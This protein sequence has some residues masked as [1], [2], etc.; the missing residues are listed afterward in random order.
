MKRSYTWK[1]GKKRK[2]SDSN[3]D[4]S[5]KG[6][7]RK[8][9]L[10]LDEKV[11][12][13]GGKSGYILEHD[14][15]DDETE[16]DNNDY[17]IKKRIFTTPSNN[18]RSY[19]MGQQLISDKREE[20]GGKQQNVAAKMK[21]PYLTNSCSSKF[22]LSSG[23]CGNGRPT[24]TA[25]YSTSSSFFDS[26]AKTKRKKRSSTSTSTTS[27]KKSSTNPNTTILQRHHIVT[28][29]CENQSRETCL[30]TIDASLGGNSGME[31]Q[32]TKTGNG[33]TTY[34][35]TLNLLKFLKPDEILLNEGRRNS[36]L[37]KKIMEFF[38]TSN[39]N[40]GCVD[41]TNAYMTPANNNNGMLEE[42]MEEEEEE[43]VVKFLPRH[44]FDQTRG[45]EL[46]QK[47]IREESH[48]PSSLEEYII[49]A[50]SHALL[51]Y[52][53]LCLGV[54]FHRHS[55][56]LSI[57][58]GGVYRMSIDRNTIQHLELLCNAKTGKLRHSLLGTIGLHTKTSVGQRLLR[59]NLIA[60]PIK[61]QTIEARLDLVQ[62]LLEDEEFFYSVLEHLETLPDIHKMLAHLALVPSKY[63]FFTTGAQKKKSQGGAGGG[64]NGERP[65]VTARIASK[66]ISAL[67]CIKS[68]LSAIPSFAQVIEDKLH[69]LDMI[70]EQQQR[71]RQ[72]QQ[73]QQESIVGKTPHQYHQNSPL[74][75]YKTPIT[76]ITELTGR[77]S[78]SVQRTREATTTPSSSSAT[79][80]KQKNQLLH[81]IL[82][83][84]K[85]PALTQILDKVKD[86]FTESTQYSKN[87][88]AMRH[89]ECFALKPN[90]DGMMD[91]LR[92]A[93]LANIDDIYKCA[94]SYAEKFG[95]PLVQV[96][97]NTKRGHYLSIPINLA[98]EL[99]PVFIQPVKSGKFIHCTTEEVHSLNLR[100]QENVQDLLIMT[101]TRIQ[102][103]MEV[104]RSRYDCLASLSDAIAL[105][106]MCHCFA[107][108]VV[109]SRLPW[110]RPIVTDNGMEGGGS[111]ALSIRNGRYA[112]DVSSTGLV[113]SPFS[114]NNNEGKRGRGRGGENQSHYIPNDA[115]ATSVQN[116]TIITG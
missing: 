90:T 50:S 31:L 46:L 88:H 100:A 12:R 16:P 33:Q 43:T 56:Y 38:D 76:R 98:N 67:V 87:S 32:I 63:S 44:Y 70:D 116:F 77:Y 103:V 105:L 8:R 106:D 30:A 3:D 74:H 22:T 72:N 55:L 5:K 78:S 1:G 85:Q 68:I 45:A 102:E 73:Q 53:Q 42:E 11:S 39:K 26:T 23:T 40:G 101:H 110:S 36:H 65:F 79:T 81:A 97:Y 61:L 99:P 24:S 60:P 107:D 58:S 28:A 94:D 2:K 57:D 66:G 21:N 4:L 35:E 49:L 10:D 75:P 20:E 91:V 27:K 37:A 47:V 34:N 86:I 18:R 111:G 80:R 9:K 95:I 96:K 13:N 15:D 108:N 41:Q 109:S 54:S 19:N 6:G 69:N 89:Q 52:I 92:K 113:S 114:N 62:T 115:Y 82:I 104:A 59:T 7:R 17:E 51:Q 83:A 64:N 84:L 71:T 25:A 48:D 93:F 112:I 14:D 29:I